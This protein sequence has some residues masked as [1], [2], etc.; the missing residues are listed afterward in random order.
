MGNMYDKI[1]EDIKQAMRDGDASKRNCLRMVISEIKNMTVNAGREVTDEVCIAVLH[2]QEKMHVDSVEQFKAAGREDLVQ[3]EEQEL[4]VIRAYL[5]KTLSNAET[6]AAVEKVIADNGFERS[7]K[8]MGQI[9][10][11]LAGIPG[12]SQVPGVDKR[13]AAVYLSKELK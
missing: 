1:A 8:M 5:P 11:A 2:R 12:I 3:K 7:K 13:A 4:S 6:E 10:K 9:M